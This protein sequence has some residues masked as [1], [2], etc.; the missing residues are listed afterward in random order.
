MVKISWSYHRLLPFSN[1]KSPDTEAK[2]T[3]LEILHKKDL[4]I[5][6]NPVYFMTQYMQRV[7]S[8]GDPKDTMMFQYRYHFKYPAALEKYNAKYEASVIAQETAIADSKR[9]FDESEFQEAS[10][11][12]K[13]QKVSDIETRTLRNREQN[14]IHAEANGPVSEVAF[15]TFFKDCG[16]MIDL[17]ITNNDTSTIAVIEFELQD[18]VLA[19]LTLSGKKIDEVQ[20]TIMQS[21]QSTLFVSNYNP[22]SSED[23]IRQMFEKFGTVLEVR[24]PSLM[25]NTH[26]R[27]CYVQ[28]RSNSEAIAALDLDGTPTDTG[29]ISVAIS[30]PTKKQERVGAVYEGREIF[31][32]H[33]D[34]QASEEDVKNH[35]QSYGKVVSVRMPLKSGRAQGFG[36]VVFESPEEAQS[37]LKANASRILRKVINVEIAQVKKG[38]PNN[39]KPSKPPK[40][41]NTETSDATTEVAESSHKTTDKDVDDKSHT[42]Y[43]G[44]T[45][46]FGEIKAKTVGVLHL[47]DKVNDAR[48]GALFQPF[49]AIRRIDMHPENEGAIVEFEEV[50]AAGQATI[51]LDGSYFEGQKLA[52]VSVEELYRHKPQRNTKQPLFAPTAVRKSRAIRFKT[53]PQSSSAN[54]DSAPPEKPFNNAAFRQF[55]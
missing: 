37:A 26:R 31:V 16:S 45:K 35:F 42:E 20:V 4:N 32:T 44:A 43:K 13:R 10:A 36:F 30:D 7:F 6:N 40:P 29:K 38:K 33:L 27:F 53:T 55:L 22:Q 5:L 12:T 52:I 3:G 49:G 2:S 14:M 51:K 9:K 47:N 54:T 46:S 50:A 1:T 8:K 11:S 41:L 48:V 39:L 25:Y 34:F 17:K 23:D 28:M 24:L 21:N 19:A 15:R 18:D